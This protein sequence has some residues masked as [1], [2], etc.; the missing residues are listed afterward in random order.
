MHKAFV[1]IV[2]FSLAIGCQ[3]NKDK[4]Q[5]MVDEIEK[6]LTARIPELA[7]IDTVYLLVR[8][9]SPRDIATLQAIEYTWAATEAKRNGSADSSMFDDKSY[10]ILEQSKNADSVTIMYYE[11]APLVIF[12]TKSQ[13]RKQ[14]D[15]R[16]FFDRKFSVVRKYS[17]IT[18]VSQTDNTPL[19]I[20]S[21]KLFSPEEYRTLE[22]NN[23]LKYY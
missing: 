17:L 23:T 14:L 12:K 2:S 9:L 15:T 11:A 18:K 13:E 8:A 22:R 7:T 6:E 16:M 10:E 3:S 19:N 20:Q 4:F 5:P 1:Y 21:Y